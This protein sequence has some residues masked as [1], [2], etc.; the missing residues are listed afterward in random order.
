MPFWFTI[1]GW[2]PKEFTAALFIKLILY[3]LTFTSRIFIL[4][5]PEFASQKSP[6]CFAMEHVFAHLNDCHVILR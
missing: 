3:N 2:Q 1:T 5:W 6:G 4:I